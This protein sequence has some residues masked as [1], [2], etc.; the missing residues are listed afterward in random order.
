[1][2]HVQLRLS[3]DVGHVTEILKQYLA[4]TKP[5]IVLGNAV[6]TFAGL[7]LASRGRIHIPLFVATLIGLCL[8]MASACV[9]NNYIDRDVDAK[10]HRTKNRALA[11]GAVGVSRALSFAILLGLSGVL[12]LALYTNLLTVS[13]ALTGFFLYVVVYSIWK[14]WTVYGTLVGSLAGATPPVVGYCAV[15]NRFDMGAL[16]LFLMLFLWQMPHFFSIAMYR[17]EDYARASLPVL[18]VKRGA[19]VT[20]THMLRYIVAFTAAALL[21]TLYGYMGYTHLVFA[22]LLGSGWFILCLQ[23]FRAPN[24]ARWARQ[25]FLFS[26]VV[27]LTISL[28][29]SGESL[30]GEA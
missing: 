7:A 14:R 13:V 10:M 29:I 16:I 20:K 1:M 25:M 30:A 27:I 26:L 8:V 23:G 22:T 4:L 19:H 28:L 2:D 18:P 3:R 12:L 6:T 17:L 15:S 9:C 5:G 24:D 21:L 11:S